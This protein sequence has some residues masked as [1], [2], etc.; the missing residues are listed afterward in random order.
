M[1]VGGR[2]NQE[3]ESRLWRRSLHNGQAEEAE[4]YN[5]CE[6]VRESD[7]TIVVKIRANKRGLH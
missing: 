6:I 4:R 2:T 3:T 5:L 1:D 7:K